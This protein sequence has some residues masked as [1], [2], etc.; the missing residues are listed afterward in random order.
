MPD[1]DTTGEGRPQNASQPPAAPQPEDIDQ[2]IEAQVD[3]AR[4]EEMLDVYDDLLAT[5]WNRIQPTLGRVTVIT[6]MERTLALAREKHPLVEH[7]QATPEGMRLDAL[8][9]Q[10]DEQDRDDVRGA[11]REVITTLI[12]ILVML[13]GDILVRQLL[14][15]IERRGEA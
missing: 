5:I 6:I 8:R 13:T 9:R 12:D 10:F 14:N 7:L 2:I 11:L 1:R 3:Q 15:E 4:Q